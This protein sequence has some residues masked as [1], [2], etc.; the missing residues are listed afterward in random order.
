MA[1]Q[2]SLLLKGSTSESKQ[3]VFERH[4]SHFFDEPRNESYLNRE[5]VFNLG[6]ESESDNDTA[7][8]IFGRVY[9]TGI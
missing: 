9:D 5:E 6:F 2:L 1:L 3:M 7:L 4:I 8:Q